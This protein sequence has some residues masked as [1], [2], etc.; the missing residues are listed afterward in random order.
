MNE[1]RATQLGYHSRLR[2]V[3]HASL[4]VVYNT[5]SQLCSAAKRTTRRPAIANNSA[6]QLSVARFIC[7]QSNFYL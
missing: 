1:Q 2:L 7:E 4:I 5:P 6:L 3:S